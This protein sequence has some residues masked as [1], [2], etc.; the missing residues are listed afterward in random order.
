MLLEISICTYENGEFDVML[1]DPASGEGIEL[2]GF[3]RLS[4]EQSKFIDRIAPACVWTS[5]RSESC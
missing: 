2:S 5:Y 4:P 3:K 1:Q